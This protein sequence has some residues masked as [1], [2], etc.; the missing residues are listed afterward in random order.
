MVK[1]S[2]KFN[3]YAE[4]YVTARRIANIL[5][6]PATDCINIPNEGTWKDGE[7]IRVERDDGVYYIYER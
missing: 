6:R 7:P 1:M 4:E 2:L 5:F 3:L